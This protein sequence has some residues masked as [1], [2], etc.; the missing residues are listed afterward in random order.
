MFA[1]IMEPLAKGMVKHLCRVKNIKGHEG[2][3]VDCV[4]EVTW[5]QGPGNDNLEQASLPVGTVGMAVAL[6]EPKT[7]LRFLVATPGEGSNKD[8]IYHVSVMNLELLDKGEG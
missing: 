5:N 4:R 2:E 6:A 3:M 7:V 8:G 1:S